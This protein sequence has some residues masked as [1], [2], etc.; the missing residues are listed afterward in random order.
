[1]FQPRYKTTAE[2]SY[3]GSRIHAVHYIPDIAVEI[4]GQFRGFFVDTAAALKAARESVDQI[5]KAKQEKKSK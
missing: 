5:V 4:D 1:M 2:E 3:R